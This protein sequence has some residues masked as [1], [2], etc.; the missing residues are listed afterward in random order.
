MDVLHE[1]RYRLRNREWEDGVKQGRA[2]EFEGALE[3]LEDTELR[4]SH[5]DNE[6]RVRDL[7]NIR[8]QKREVLEM[9][10]E[11]YGLSKQYKQVADS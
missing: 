1:A 3:K 5:P 6:N 10:D 9:M 8:A 11:E 7:E 4:A 2:R